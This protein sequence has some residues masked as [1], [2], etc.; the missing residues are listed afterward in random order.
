MEQ[1]VASAEASEGSPGPRGA[2]SDP[3]AAAPNNEAAT[4]PNAADPLAQAAALRW[5]TALANGDTA[6]LLDMAA[7]PFKTNDKAV[8]KRAEL[9]AM[10]TDLAGEGVRR[11]TSV[12]VVTA[13]QLRAVIGKLPSSLDDTTGAQLYSAIEIGKN[14]MLILVLAQRAGNWHPV[15]MVRR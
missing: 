15:G 10:L 4:R 6:R 7:L 9:S 11:Q 3:P 2:E 8:S 5:F 1:E 13:A 14:E 12:R